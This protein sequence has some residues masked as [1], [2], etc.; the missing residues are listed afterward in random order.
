[1]ITSTIVSVCEYSHH[2]VIYI[3]CIEFCTPLLTVSQQLPERTETR[4]PIPFQPVQEA[5]QIV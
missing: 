1:M 5:M 4:R 3:V 2:N